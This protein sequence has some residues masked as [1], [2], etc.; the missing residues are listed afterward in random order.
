[1]KKRKIH[2]VTIL[3]GILLAVAVI[4]SHT[5]QP[6][7]ISQ[8]KQQAKT[9]QEKK[10]QSSSHEDKSYISMNSISLPTTV[11]VHLNLA[12]YCLFEILGLEEKD[13]P[14]VAD[15]NLHPRKLFQTLFRVIISPNAP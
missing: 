7:F 9:E 1:M 2:T 5:F 13:E 8:E 15:S 3:A 12:V 6:V 11:H 4:F 10:D 14:A